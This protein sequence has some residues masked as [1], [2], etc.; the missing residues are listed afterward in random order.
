MAADTILYISDHGPRSSSIL[1]AL[2]ATGYDVVSTDSSTQSVALLFVMHSVSATVLDQHSIEQSSFNLVRSLRTLRPDVP[3]VLIC[4]D[5]IDR[6]PAAVDYCVN[7]GQ[8]LENVTSDLQ[9]ILAKKSA[10]VGPTDC[11]SCA[12]P[13]IRDRT[14]AEGLDSIGRE[15]EC[16]RGN[17]SDAPDADLLTG[18]AVQPGG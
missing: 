6:L 12:S 9:R 7:A 16:G 18:S 11:C 1:A 8:P 3:I 4:A 13:K 17:G 10:A 15:R 14:L 5:R 2:E